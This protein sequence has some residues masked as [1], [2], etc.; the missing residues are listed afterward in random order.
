MAEASTMCTMFHS[1]KDVIG[2]GFHVYSSQGP[3]GKTIFC[4]S[5]GV[6]RDPRCSASFTLPL[7]LCFADQFLSTPGPCHREQAGL[8]APTPFWR[9]CAI[10]SK[11]FY[12]SR[13]QCPHLTTRSLIFTSSFQ[14]HHFLLTKPETEIA[15][16]EKNRNQATVAESERGG[17]KPCP[18]AFPSHPADWA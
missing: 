3:L 8:L 1:M 16:V 7:Y 11:S 18:P 17:A 15:Y 6:S 12:L 2:P 13:L 14:T 9:R 4:G 5:Q 10:S